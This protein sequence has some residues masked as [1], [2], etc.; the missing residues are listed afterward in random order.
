[1]SSKYRRNPPLPLSALTYRDHAYIVPKPEET[2]LTPAASSA[3]D[4][5][6]SNDERISI[7]SG[8]TFGNHRRRWSVA[9]PSTE[10]REEGEIDDLFRKREP[11]NPSDENA[12]F[13]RIKTQSTPRLAPFHLMTT[14]RS[15]GSNMSGRP[16]GSFGKSISPPSYGTPL[17][18]LREE[19]SENSDDELEG[20]LDSPLSPRLI[21]KVDQLLGRGAYEAGMAMEAEKKIL[22]EALARSVVTQ[23]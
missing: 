10:A 5:I 8:G 16:T 23:S 21:S 12:E 13:G 1:M 7:V 15:A 22:Q 19:R 18:G 20:I 17:R 2:A 11:G 14:P 3:N 9:S 4:H 6:S